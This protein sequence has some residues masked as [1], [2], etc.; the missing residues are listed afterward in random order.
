MGYLC[1]SVDF[2]G[3]TCTEGT[4]V[5]SDKPMIIFDDSYPLPRSRRHLRVR[6]GAAVSAE[7]LHAREGRGDVVVDAV[8]P[9]EAVVRHTVVC[10]VQ[11]S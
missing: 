2:K 10:Q 7:A 3:L 11:S 6:L 8:L 1:E 4:K 9:T 5:D